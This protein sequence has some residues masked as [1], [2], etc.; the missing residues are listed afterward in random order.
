MKIQAGALRGIALLAGL[1]QFC[2]SFHSDRITFQVR[3]ADLRRPGNSFAKNK[4]P[5]DVVNIKLPGQILEA[6]VRVQL[7]MRGQADWSTPEIAVASILSAEVAGDVPWMLLNYVPSERNAALKQFSDPNVVERG[8]ESYRAFEKFERT[9]WAQVREFTVVFVRGEDID[10][11]PT[12][13]NIAL[14]KTPSGWKQTDALVNDD[15]LDV[16]TTALHTGGVQ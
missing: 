14:L 1:G 8:R 4:G 2:C 16:I 5:E 3:A 11:D 12:L 15:A 10:G 7:I 9:G 6:P 13:M